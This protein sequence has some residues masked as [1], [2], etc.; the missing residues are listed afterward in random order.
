MRSASLI[1][2][3]VLSFSTNA[4]ACAELFGALLK[5]EDLKPNMIV[6]IDQPA[7]TLGQD[8]IADTL[9]PDLGLDSYLASMD[10]RGTVLITK[11]VFTAADVAEVHLLSLNDLESNAHGHISPR[12][13]VSPKTLIYPYRF[14]T[15]TGESAKFRLVGHAEGDGQVWMNLVLINTPD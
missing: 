12:N 5:P 2:I 9:E 8:D 15:G 7:P 11:V 14:T 6:Q 3:S 13:Q 10:V 4:Y 1:L